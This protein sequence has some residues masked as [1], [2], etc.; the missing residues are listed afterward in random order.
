MQDL[1][2]KHI[3]VTAKL[4]NPPRTA[5][6]VDDWMRRVVEAVNMK[7]LFGPHVTRCDTPGNEGVTGIVC[8]ETSHASIHVWDTLD[9]PFM[10]FDL[11]S[12]M[13]FDPTIITDM[14][15]E[16]DP[17]Y[18]ESMMV[19]RNTTIEV[20]AKDQQQII[21]IK[22]LMTDEDWNHYLAA[23]R[24]S[25]KG[26]VRTA[27]QK[28]AR[29]LYNRLEAKFSA[30]GVTR[31]K[32]YLDNHLWTINSIKARAK[33]KNLD[34]DLDAEWYRAALDDAKKMWPKIIVHQSEDVFWRAEV[35]RIDP[36]LGYTKGNCRIIPGALNKA[37]WNWTTEELLI[38]LDLLS[39]EVDA[40]SPGL[41]RNWINKISSL[42]K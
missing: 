42:V 34:F 1:D 37:K 7:I 2:H 24:V 14:I 23:N 26:S 4:R 33:A 16:F 38:L 27:E 20:V 11:Y 17:Y 8:I 32:K 30:K 6:Q 19:D 3:I 25:G 15:K 10:K 39:A 36:K 31:L 5:E 21:P 13:R 28:K 18:I 12:C 35:D 40:K 22:S 41:F 29:S 9:V